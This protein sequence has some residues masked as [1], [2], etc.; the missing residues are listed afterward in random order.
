LTVLIH[1]IKISLYEPV[2]KLLESKLISNEF[3]VFIKL[4]LNGSLTISRS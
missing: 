4:G 1:R 2:G 3:D